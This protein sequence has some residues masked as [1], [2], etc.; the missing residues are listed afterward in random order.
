[1]AWVSISG[2]SDLPLWHGFSSCHGAR[3]SV[4]C[5]SSR[6]QLYSRPGMTSGSHR[7]LSVQPASPPAKSCI[8]REASQGLRQEG[9]VGLGQPVWC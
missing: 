8:C 7:V 1:M 9:G 2:V 4:L 3:L 6:G 5:S